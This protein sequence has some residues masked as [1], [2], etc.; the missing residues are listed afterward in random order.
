MQ[1]DLA[2]YWP[3]PERGS[4]IEIIDCYL[5]QTGQPITTKR[6]VYTSAEFAGK[7][8]LR[9]DEFDPNGKWNDAWLLRKEL[10][11]VVEFGDIYP[12]GHISLF[13][14]G[15]ELLWGGVMEIGE[16]VENDVEIDLSASTGV[17]P[18]IGQYG[19]N[20]TTLID[21]MPSFTNGAG[22]TFNDVAVIHNVQTFYNF[23]KTKLFGKRVYE[24][25]HWQAKGIGIVQIDYY[26]NGA[27]YSKHFAKMVKNNV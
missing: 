10:R 14:Y 16:T 4:P 11:G 25:R 8:I 21:V 19:K 26:A 24:A 18:F 27:S 20:K 12:K 5:S 17:Y 23:G 7:P 2:A 6:N 3:S 15:K 9:I 13:R 1:H 22:L